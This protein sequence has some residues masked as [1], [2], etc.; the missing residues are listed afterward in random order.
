MIMAIIIKITKIPITIAAIAPPSSS[1]SLLVEVESICID[2][3]SLPSLDL[4][5]GGVFPFFY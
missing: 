1:K 2:F 4:V 3:F 5:G